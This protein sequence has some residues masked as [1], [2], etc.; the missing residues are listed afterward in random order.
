MVSVRH[1]NASDLPR[2]MELVQGSASAAQWGHAAF[3]RL[4]ADGNEAVRLVMVVEEKGEVAGFVAGCDSAGE[5]EIENLVVAGSARRHGLGSRLLG[6]FMHHARGRNARALFLEVRESNMAARA[7]Y[8]RWAFREAGRRK[9]Y[10][11][12]PCEDALILKLSFP[13]P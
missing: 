4:F 8:A 9:R 3:E 13:Q 1:A 2:M 10:Y 5:W 7:L 6:E 11:Q 12:D